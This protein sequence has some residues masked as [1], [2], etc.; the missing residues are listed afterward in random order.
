MEVPMEQ[1]N[2]WL[3]FVVCVLFGAAY[4]LMLGFGF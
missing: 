3:E 2:T 4:G 1:N